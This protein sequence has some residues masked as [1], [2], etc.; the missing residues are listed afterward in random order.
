MECIQTSRLVL[1]RRINDPKEQDDHTK[2][3]GG[4]EEDVYQELE[5]GMT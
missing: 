1:D 2:M 5:E 4:S 3:A